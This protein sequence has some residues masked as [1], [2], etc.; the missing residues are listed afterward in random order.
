MARVLPAILLAAFAGALIAAGA[1]VSAQAKRN[2]W[3]GVFTDAQAQRGET[4]YKA[5]C[6]FCHR[7]DL[8][9]SVD[10]GPPLRDQQFVGRWEGLPL[11]EMLKVISEE[12]PENDPGTLKPQEYLDIMTF[13]LKFNGFPAGATELQLSTAG[14]VVFNAARPGA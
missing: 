4:V 12:M 14:D 10:G 11:S 8:K 5:K 1:P 3:D 7:D 13:L 9:G 6:G 2:V